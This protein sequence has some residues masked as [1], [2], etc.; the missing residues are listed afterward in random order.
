MTPALWGRLGGGGGGHRDH[1]HHREER[2][3]EDCKSDQTPGY[4][5]KHGHPHRQE[6]DQ[7]T[8][9][10][11][12]E[13]PV[14]EQKEKHWYDI[15]EENKKKLEVL[16]GPTLLVGNLISDRSAEVSLPGLHLSVEAY[17]PTSSTKRNRRRYGCEPSLAC[18][19]RL[20]VHRTRHT[21]GL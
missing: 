19:W 20:I 10:A 11:S 14:Q 2:W 8:F 5:E 6:T 21:L 7:S 4:G 18:P 16:S 17:L 12:A 15:D 13:Q 9:Q 1:H 3:G